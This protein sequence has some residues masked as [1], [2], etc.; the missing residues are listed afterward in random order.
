[1]LQ[2]GLVIS[3]EK[4]LRPVGIDDQ[5]G[6]VSPAT[7]GCRCG[8]H[9]TAMARVHLDVPASGNFDKL[10]RSAN[11]DDGRMT[12]EWAAVASARFC[13]SGTRND[14]ASGNERSRSWVA[15][16]QSVIVGPSNRFNLG[17]AD[18]SM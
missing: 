2:L 12:G 16:T 4:R 14:A 6:S 17:P 9:P 1:L 5:L 11:W 10:L 18:H 3:S 8:A 15:R 7:S 13:R